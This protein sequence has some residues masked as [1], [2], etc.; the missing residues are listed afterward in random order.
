MISRSALPNSR[1][2]YSSAMTSC[3]ARSAS[4]RA[5]PSTPRSPELAAEAFGQEAGGAA[6]DVDVL[7]DE[8]GVDAGDEV[9]GVEVHVLDRPLSLAAR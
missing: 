6:G 9:V 1:V 5:R 8:V 4:S 3:G 7:A 2:S